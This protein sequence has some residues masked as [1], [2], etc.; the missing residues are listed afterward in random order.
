MNHK[1]HRKR[2][3]GLIAL[4]LISDI[5]YFSLVNPGNSNSFVVIVG[6]ILIALSIYILVLALTK[7]FAVFFL[8]SHSSQRR[9]TI[10]LT[11]LLVFLLLMQSIGQLSLRDVLTIVPLMV[12]LYLYLT[13]ITKNKIRP[14]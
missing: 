14:T 2:T 1:T 8:I 6:C 10:F 9:L 12:V 7:L 4:L 5:S 13:Y 3:V 11:I